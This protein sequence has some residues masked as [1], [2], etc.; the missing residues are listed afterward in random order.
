MKKEKFELSL[1]T[2][3]IQLRDLNVRSWY[4]IAQFYHR[5]RRPKKNCKKIT[6]FLSN[7]II[8]KTKS[9]HF[10]NQCKKNN[11]IT[12]PY[13]KTCRKRRKLNKSILR[14]HNLLVIYP[15]INFKISLL[16]S[17]FSGN[18]RGAKNKQKERTRRGPNAPELLFAAI[19]GCKLRRVRYA[20]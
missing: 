9:Y 16:Y 6:F 7:L 12:L 18:K 8:Y 1:E 15:S 3:I 11:Y 4:L 10:R 19:A 17:R 20:A 13:P 5:I 2:S 14:I